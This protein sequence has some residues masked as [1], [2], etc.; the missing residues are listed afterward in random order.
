M[1]TYAFSLTFDP[2]TTNVRGTFVENV[3]K[4]SKVNPL[5]CPDQSFS[6][7]SFYLAPDLALQVSSAVVWVS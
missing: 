7:R 2:Y 4:T 5:Y 3:K 1:L 6:S